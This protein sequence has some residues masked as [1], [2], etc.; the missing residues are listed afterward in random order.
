MSPEV[1]IPV[2]DLGNLLGF[3]DACRVIAGLLT[4]RDRARNRPQSDRISPWDRLLVHADKSQQ[5]MGPLVRECMLLYR[6]EE[7]RALV[8]RFPPTADGALRHLVKA[9]D[10]VDDLNECLDQCFQDLSEAHAKSGNYFTRNDVARLMVAAVDPQ[11]GHRVLDPVCGSAGLL[12]GVTRH[13]SERT[14]RPTNLELTGQDVHAS[15][16]HVARMNLTARNLMAHLP[17]PMDSLAR[18]AESSYDVILANPPFNDSLPAEPR[19]DDPRWSDAAAPPRDNA[20]LA[21]MLHI[22]HALAP[23]G[24]A[25][26]LM[27]DGAATGARQAEQRVRERLVQDDVV[28][29]VVALPPGL[30][31]HS[32]APCCLWLL[33]TDKGPRDDWGSSDRQGKVLFINARTAYEPVP[34]TRKRRLSPE[35]VEQVLYTLGAWRGAAGQYRDEAGWCRSV[36]ATEIAGQLYDLQPPRYTGELAVDGAPGQRQIEELAAELRDRFEEARMLEADLL[37]VLDEL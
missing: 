24:R 19:A 2:R 4:L 3:H 16:L 31:P 9:V 5:P 20:N 18:P 17:D 7:Y 1:R 12:I 15:T 14:G 23:A 10:R 26:I 6:D 33:N 13:V 36:D 11:E 29:C 30:F 37:R 35:G 34:R 27:A 8:P 21:W 32:R 22:A 25:A 28:E